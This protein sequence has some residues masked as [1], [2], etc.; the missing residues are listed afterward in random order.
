MF[1]CVPFFY[2]FALPHAQFRILLFFRILICALETTADSNNVIAIN[3]F[4]FIDNLKKVNNG[5]P[6]FEI[7]ASK[8]YFTA[9]NTEK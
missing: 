7:T 8:L 4:H 2:F 9:G 6:M 3:P 5:R 1:F